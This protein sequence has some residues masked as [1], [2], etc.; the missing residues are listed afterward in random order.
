[1]DFERILQIGNQAR[2]GEKLSA[3]DQTFVREAVPTELA[4]YPRIAYPSR[5]RHPSGAIIRG[6]VV[7][8]FVKGAMVLGA[9]RTLGPKYYATRLIA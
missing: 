6:A 2:Q 9:R 3:D 8:T 7:R 4:A 5:I 1:M